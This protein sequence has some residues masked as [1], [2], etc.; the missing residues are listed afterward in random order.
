MFQLKTDGQKVEIIFLSEPN[1]KIVSAIESLGLRQQSPT[2]WIAEKV[3]DVILDKLKNFTQ[4]FSNLGTEIIEIA[5][6][7][8]VGIQVEAHPPSPLPETNEIE[9]LKR[10]VA[11]L[12]KLLGVC[13]QKLSN[14]KELSNLKATPKSK[15]SRSKASSRSGG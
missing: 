11:D 9:E 5:T 2:E 7:E 12:K 1:P 15:K 8:A 3:E 13:S 10:E 14:L 4:R 6:V